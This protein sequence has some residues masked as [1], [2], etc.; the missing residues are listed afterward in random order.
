[1]LAMGGG[2]IGEDTWVGGYNKVSPLNI[3]QPF[4][5]KGFRYSKFGFF[6][7]FTYYYTYQKNMAQENTEN[8]YE[9]P[10]N[11]LGGSMNLNI[12][13]NPTD[14]RSIPF[15]INYSELEVTVRDNFRDKQRSY[16]SLHQLVFGL[17]AN[18]NLKHK[19]NEASYLLYHVDSFTLTDDPNEVEDFLL[20]ERD[21]E[22]YKTK[23][24]N[25]PIVNYSG[26]VKSLLVFYNLNSIT[27]CVLYNKE[28]KTI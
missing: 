9:K 6:I 23:R 16:I 17:S 11:L 26:K 28:I 4:T 20:T 22:E 24:E 12:D 14:Y 18:Q 8:N 5:D 3:L 21:N 13:T 27:Y 15:G 25:I 1:M 2:S 19:C 7:Y 10:D